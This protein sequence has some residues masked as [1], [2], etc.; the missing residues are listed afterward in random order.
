MGQKEK[1][2]H[3]HPAGLAAGT[4]VRFT[5]SG[6]GNSART[7][8]GTVQQDVAPGHNGRIRVIVS[9]GSG[10]ARWM[11]PFIAHVVTL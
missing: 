11:F 6:R 7:Y 5:V 1:A 10:N 9:D 8:E 4:R 2:P 3:P